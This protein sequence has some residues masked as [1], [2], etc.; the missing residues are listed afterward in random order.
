M[1]LERRLFVGIFPPAAV[2]RALHE[3]ARGV[4][5]A[6]EY[7]IVPADEVHLTLRFLGATAEA[8]IPAVRAALGRDLAG[9]RAPSLSIRGTGA[10]PDAERARVLWAGIAEQ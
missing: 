3:A 10:F 4:L 9:F 5:S 7:R 1:S 2:G 8:A 6:S